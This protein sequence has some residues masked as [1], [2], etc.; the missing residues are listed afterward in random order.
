VGLNPNFSA[1]TPAVVYEID[2]GLTSRIHTY[3]GPNVPDRR[4]SVD[5]NSRD[6]TLYVT[7][8][9]LDDATASGLG[10]VIAFATTGRTVGG[11]TST[12][13]VLVDGQTF[14]AGNGLY[15]Q[16]NCPVY[17]RRPGGDDTLLILTNI[18]ATANNPVLEFWLDTNLHPKDANNNLAYRGNPLN[19]ARGWSGQ[20]DVGTGEV[21]MAAL[22]GGFHVLDADDL[23]TSFDTGRWW[24][25]VDT[26]P[27]EPCNEPFADID[28]DKDVDLM[29]YAVFQRCITASGPVAVEC[30]CFNR[31]GDNDL[32][33]FDFTAFEDC[34]T[35]PDVPWS[36][37][38]TPFCSP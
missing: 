4:V 18:S 34:S 35:G 30:T 12:F 32:D 3:T 33:S 19:L 13:E 38:L 10:D 16:P 21:W 37:G 2:L 36:Q 6:G 11:T 8:Q 29:D 24:A 25:D 5:I 17:R 20:Q 22:R 28:G 14:N 1:S 27:F 15:I 23:A 9:H 26:P 31:D 7:S